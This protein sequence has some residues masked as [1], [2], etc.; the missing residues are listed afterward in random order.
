MS[1][2]EGKLVGVIGDEVQ[3]RLSSDSAD[4]IHDHLE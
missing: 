3:P 2:D 4:C 1:V